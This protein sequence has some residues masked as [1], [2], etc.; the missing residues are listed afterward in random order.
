MAEDGESALELLN[1]RTFDLV[2][3]DALMP[4]LDGFSVCDALRMPR[5][6]ATFP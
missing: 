6:R 1:A 5:L 2:L 4:G 3:L